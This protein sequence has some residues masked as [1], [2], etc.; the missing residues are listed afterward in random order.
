MYKTTLTCIHTYRYIH[1]R[2]LNLSCSQGLRDGAVKTAPGSQEE[3]GSC[4]GIGGRKLDLRPVSPEP[5]PFQRPTIPKSSCSVA[6]G[7]EL[8]SRLLACVWAAPGLGT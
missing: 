4:G 2:G 3:R 6:M 7:P 1:V 8:R 5:Q